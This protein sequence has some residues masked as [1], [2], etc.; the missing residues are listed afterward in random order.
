MA[1]IEDRLAD[2]PTNWWAPDHACVEAMLR[3]CGMTVRHRPGHEIYVCTPDHPRD[4]VVA[5]LV[6]DELG[7]VREVW[8]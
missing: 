4:P 7:A 8:R 1:F 5:A 3:T 6:H 2:D